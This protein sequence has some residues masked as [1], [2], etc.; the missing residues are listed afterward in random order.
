M[1]QSCILRSASSGAIIASQ[2]TNALSRTWF[3]ARRLRPERTTSILPRKLGL[4][5]SGGA[6]SMA[7]AYLCRQWELQFRSRK[8]ADVSVTAF[9]VD[10]KA[11]PEST[12]E[13][14]IVAGYLRDLGITTQIL[15]LDWSGINNSALETQARRLRFQALGQACRDHGI[16]ALLL[17]HHQDDNV[18]TTIWRLASGARGPGLAGIA[19]TARIPECHGLYGVAGSGDSTTVYSDAFVEPPQSVHQSGRRWNMSTG[20][21]LIHRPLLSFSKSDL[22]ATCH[23][24][25]VPYVSD[26]TNF[27][28]TL[29][30][31]NAIRSMILSNSFP[32]ALQ[33]DSL[34]SLAKNCQ[35]LAR[36]GDIL[37]NDI[38]KSQCKLLDFS[39][40]SGTFTVQFRPPSPSLSPA[41]QTQVQSTEKDQEEQGI[42]AQRRHQLECLTLRRLT[43]LI[44]P[45][46]DNHWQL[47]KFAEFTGRVFPAPGATT[48]PITDEDSGLKPKPKSKT[49][50]SQKGR[51]QDAI[52]DDRK[53]FTI[54]GV[55]FEPVIPLPSPSNK[56][57]KKTPTATPTPTGIT[58]RDRNTWLLTRQPYFRYRDPVTRFDLPDLLSSP[59]PSPTDVD[60]KQQQ[61]PTTHI[62]WLLW[63][64]R[65]WLRAS[66]VPLNSQTKATSTSPQQ[67]VYAQPQQAKDYGNESESKENEKLQL[68]I[69][70][71]RQSDLLPLR[72]QHNMPISEYE[73]QPRK[74]KQKFN[75]FRFFAK[76]DREAP[77]QSRYRIPVLALEG[78]GADMPL[79]LPTMDLAFPDLG[80]MP[81]TLNWEWKYK[82]IDLEAL[83]CMGSV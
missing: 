8:D 40:A 69:R 13:A 71:L 83:R 42:S 7:L 63:D 59:L 31:R 15:Q 2:F 79:A 66:L 1:A 62:P 52:K 65:F 26:P 49:N 38:L 47:R 24:N 32:R 30:A 6:D 44:S 29:T 50:T 35:N 10:H 68:V 20:G 58:I 16:E 60:S 34:L 56:S 77:G 51:K 12:E 73:S 67:I 14:S 78:F 23:E 17:G 81:W 33:K 46:P 72:H 54:G 41:P 9:V 57:C 3:E 53:A 19:S 39:L 76:L 74:P 18:E 28:S 45:F 70:P 43:E 5:V 22:I 80:S 36:H 61:Q 37:S 21:I 82:M 64:N 25:N 55:I 48:M 27:D 11:R 75:A 4:A